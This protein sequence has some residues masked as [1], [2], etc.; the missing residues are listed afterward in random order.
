MDLSWLDPGRLEA[1]DLAGA[2]AVY[3]S[4]RLVDCPHELPRTVA[5]YTADLQHGWDGEPGEAFVSRDA[6]GRVVAV[7]EVHLSRRDNLHLGYLEITVD[8]LV[9]RQGLGRALYAAGVD[10]LRAAGRTLVMVE[11]FDNPHSLEFAK[12]LGLDRAIESV[13]R[14][15]DLRLLDAARL[16][17]ELVAAQTAAAA[18]ELFRMPANIPDDLMPAVVDMVTAINDAPTEGLDVEDEVF[19]AERVLAFRSAQAAHGRRTYQLAARHP[20]TG[21]LAGH[22]L[23]GVEGDRPWYG[24]QMDTSVLRDHRGHRLGL[25][26]KIGMLRWLGQA[27][28]AL[29][30][31]DTWNTAS[32]DHMI[33]VNEALGYEVVASATGFQRH[34]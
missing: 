32:N 33:A 23:V 10:R 16:D 24:H 9:R 4:A 6:D 34:L 27:E 18:Y 13:K 11:C 20:A 2:T 1:R 12:S 21:V 8:P 14:R 26:L 3:E 31:L 5:S 29:R 15:Q 7:L 17:R 28:P 22:T 30:V 25:L 19:S